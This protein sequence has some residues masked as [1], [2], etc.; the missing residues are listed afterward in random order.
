MKTENAREVLQTLALQCDPPFSEKEAETKI[1]SALQR[2]DRKDRNLAEEVRDFVVTSS[3]W[4]LTSDG[5]NRLQV[6]SRQDKKAV[7]LEL[8]RLKEKGIIE[9]HGN[10]DG[11]Y[12]RVESDCEPVNWQDASTDT[13]DLWL[14]FGLDKMAMIPP[15]SIISLAGEPNSGKTGVCMNIARE[16][17]DNWSVH[18]FSSEMG[19]GAFK[20]RVALFP[21][22]LPKNFKVAFYRRAE[23]FADVIKPGAGNL[24]IIDYLEM[25]KDF[26]LIAGHLKDIY[27][28]LDGAIAIVALQKSPGQDVGR[29][30]SFSIEKP[31]LSLSLGAGVATIA[32]L[33]EWSGKF[34]P[35]RMQYHFKL[36][37]GCRF[38][39]KQGWHRPVE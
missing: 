25:H 11:C 21:D 22:I 17:F 32:K 15:N 27:V 39:K 34:N 30:G 1:Q 19:G 13:V 18:Y 23:N 5:F 35:N 26:Y 7:V 16:N 38:I 4:F 8:L 24:N 20:R 37:D 10:R 3:G 36:V 28:K 14:P 31:V 9:R 12:R 2:K 33:K 6:T 29:G